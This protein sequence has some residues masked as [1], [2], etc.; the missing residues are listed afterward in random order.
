VPDPREQYG[1]WDWR[2]AMRCTDC[3]RRTPI[4]Y[5]RIRYYSNTLGNDV[6]W[7][8]MVCKP[9]GDVLMIFQELKK[10]LPEEAA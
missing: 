7:T 3:G 9:C 5:H 1:I 6:E 8:E 4:Y 2:Y 10:L